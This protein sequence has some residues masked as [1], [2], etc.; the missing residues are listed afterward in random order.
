LTR[1]GERSKI[2]SMPGY[3][4]TTARDVLDCIGGTPL[5]PLRR[6]GETVMSRRAPAVAGAVVFPARER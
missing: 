4:A 6:R 5:V 3:S 1:D 2:A